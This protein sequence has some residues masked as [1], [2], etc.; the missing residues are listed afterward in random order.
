MCKP[1]KPL[2]FQIPLALGLYHRDRQKDS[3]HFEWNWALGRDGL[4]L[5]RNDDGSES[6]LVEKVVSNSHDVRATRA[7][8]GCLFRPVI[9]IVCRVDS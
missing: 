9:A 1:N 8:Q 7:Q 5:A 6:H 4:V 3:E 2:P